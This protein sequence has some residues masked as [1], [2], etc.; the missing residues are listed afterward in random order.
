[1]TASDPLRVL[2]FGTPEFAVPTLRALAASRHTLVGVVSQP[3][4]PR[5]RGRE[6]QPTPVRSEAQAQGLP[7]LQPRK[8]GESEALE[9]IEE[10]RPDL[11]VVVAFGQFIPKKVRELPPHGLINGHASLLPRHRGAAPIQHAILCGDERTGITVIRIVKEMDAGDFCLVKETEI[12]EGETA[13][14]L[15]QRL[16]E[17]CAEA[18]LEATEQIATGTAVFRPQD[19]EAATA[20]PR[21]DR[22]FARLDWGEPRQALL[23][24]IA[25]STPW[26]GA[27]VSL[28][29]S[30]RRFRILEAVSGRADATTPGRVEAGDDGLRIA[31]GDGWIEIRR[32]QAPGKRPVAAAEFLRG[33][34]LTEGEEVVPE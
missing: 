20:A 33:A 23:R 22:S 25:A 11:G 29:A 30:G 1:V 19:H 8:V 15:S 17:L 3:D 21:I 18:M 14:A 4:R 9:W 7:L 2:F 34:R 6:L 24:R 28:R 5:G 26:P 12:R 10:R 31:C 27:D 13:G 16:A 32:L